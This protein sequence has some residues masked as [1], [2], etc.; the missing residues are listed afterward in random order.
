MSARLALLLADLAA[1]G[2]PA[3]H[4][5]AAN[6]LDQLVC[7]AAD[8]NNWAQFRSVLE[9]HLPSADVLIADHVPMVPGLFVSD[10]DSTM[11]GQECID[12]LA[13]F[14]GLKPQI[15]AIT[16]RAMQG[17]LDFASALHE[18]VALL[19][20]LDAAAITQCLEQLITPMPGAA[21]LVATLKAKGC[22]TVL[23]TGGFRQFADPVAS[24]LGFEHVVANQLEIAR[25]KLT[26]RVSGAIVDSGVKRAVLEAECARLDIG[27][28]SGRASL[29]TGDGANDIPMLAAAY[30]GIAYH[31]KPKT[32]AA[33]HGWIDR[34]DLTN[35]L[36]LLGIA[37]SE[38]IN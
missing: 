23:V 29:A 5:Q 28:A 15:A 2:M 22:H 6:G 38:W 8:A 4:A 19:A 32:R 26:G 13:D 16:E 33:A 30:Y 14:A 17:E 21:V 12:E 11:I 31:A 3:R 20:G 10:M 25:G 27:K 37:E 36:R 34:G 1:L 9:A 18:R 7:D 24:M 35:V